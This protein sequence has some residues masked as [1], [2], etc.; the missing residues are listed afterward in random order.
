MLVVV[1]ELL[2][3]GKLIDVPIL[4]LTTPFLLR[5]SLEVEIK[6]LVF[7][8]VVVTRAGFVRIGLTFRELLWEIVTCLHGDRQQASKRREF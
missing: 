3:I 4:A 2:Y 1:D 6:L 7:H 8:E 5:I